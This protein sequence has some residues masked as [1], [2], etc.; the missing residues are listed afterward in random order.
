VGKGNDGSRVF[1]GRFPVDSNVGAHP[2]RND[3]R[4]TFLLFVAISA[5]GAFF[6]VANIRLRALMKTLVNI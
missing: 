5:I 6:L 2:R 3:P 4:A 1:G